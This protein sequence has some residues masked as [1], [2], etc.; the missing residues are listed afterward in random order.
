MPAG[1]VFGGGPSP[2]QRLLDG[3]EPDRP[4][5]FDRSIE[6]VLGQ[7]GVLMTARGPR[8]LEQATAELLGAELYRAVREEDSGLSFEWLA[9]ELAE[10]A[11]DRIL[12]ET[13]RE[14]GS[15]Q[16]QWRLLYGLTSIGSPV[17]RLLIED[18]LIQLRKELPASAQAE[19]PEWL[20]LLPKI[21]ATGEL[22]E[23]H[24]VYGSHFAVIAGFCYP[25]DTDPSVF[26]FDIDAC[27]MVMLAS[28]GVFD[29]VQ[30][31]AG[32]DGLGRADLETEPVA[33]VALRG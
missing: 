20:R 5:W 28:A 1:L 4:G 17:L 29:D 11:A 6:A 10:A 9:E 30:Q 12:G 23:M 8:E 14:H 7:A 2:F 33:D 25:G 15:E 32:C 21:A 26:L 16:A 31:A 3:T 13:A 24:D 18:A 19:Q 22:W 27:E